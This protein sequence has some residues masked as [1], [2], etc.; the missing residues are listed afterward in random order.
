[1]SVTGVANLVTNADVD[2][3]VAWKNGLF[4]FN[5]ADISSI[6]KQLERWYDI[7]VVFEGKIPLTHFGGEVSRSSNLSQVL[8]ILETS[9]VHFEIEGRKLTVQP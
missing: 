9:G 7:D 2:E 6:M 8:K 5:D 1:L 3:A 4:R